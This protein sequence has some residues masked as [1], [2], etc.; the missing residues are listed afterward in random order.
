[1]ELRELQKIQKEFDLEYFPEFWRIEGY[2]DF[3]DRL[4]YL[5]VALAGE[6]GEFANIVKKMRREYMHLGLEE[7]ERLDQ[8]REELIDIFIYT[9]IT[10]NLL[11]M[12]LE[13]WF[14]K[15][16]SLNRERFDRYRDN[17]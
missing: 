14:R 9:V 6:V 7:R 8:L 16:L 5:V 17:G 15:K 4:E 10:A 13:E 3:L 11:E 1:M 12:D 2:E